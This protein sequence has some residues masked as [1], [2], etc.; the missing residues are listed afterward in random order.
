MNEIDALQ[1]LIYRSYQTLNLTSNCG[2]KPEEPEEPPA[3][4]NTGD[5][6]EESDAS[7]AGEEV[8]SN[9]ESKGDGS[10]AASDGSQAARVGDRNLGPRY[11]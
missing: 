7:A 1:Y 10:Q 2:G 11:S 6:D 9:A 8:K 5:T 4:Q 3:G